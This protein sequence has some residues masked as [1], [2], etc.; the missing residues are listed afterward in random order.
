MKAMVDVGLGLSGL[1]NK[2]TGHPPSHEIFE[3]Y[4]KIVIYSLLCY[5]KGSPRAEDWE[6]QI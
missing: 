6:I 2:N 5:V 4:Q 1:A 3:V